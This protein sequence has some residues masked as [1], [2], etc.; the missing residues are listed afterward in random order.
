MIR[1]AAVSPNP[2]RPGPRRY[3]WGPF[4]WYFVM[5]DGR[6]S[7]KRYRTQAEA[8][9]AYRATRSGTI[10]VKLRAPKTSR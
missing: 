5:P 9:E 6:Y 7:L 8:R 3:A 10:K 1:P 4:P 2:P